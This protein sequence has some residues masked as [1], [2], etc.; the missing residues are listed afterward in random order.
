[1][2]TRYLRKYQQVCLSAI[3]GLAILLTGCGGGGGGGSSTP[4]PTP[5]P[6]TPTPTTPVP[7]ITMSFATPTTNVGTAD[8]LT[9]SATNATSCTAS[10]AWSGVQLVSGTLSVTPTVA[11][12]TTYTLNCMG[13]GG[14]AVPVAVNLTANPISL[15]F[16]ATVSNGVPTNQN[17]SFG[18]YVVK[19]NVWNPAG[20]ATYSETDSG[21]ISLT[22]VASLN[23]AWNVVS[24]SS[25]GI[26][27]FGSIVYGLH[28]GN[29]TSTTTKLPVLV[30]AVPSTALVTGHVITNCLTTCGYD[31]TFDIFVMSS[32]APSNT[33][34][35]VEILIH[36]SDS[37]T[38]NSNSPNGTVT[39]NGVTYQVIYNGFS[40]ANWNN[41]Q[42]LAPAGTSVT[43]LNLNLNSLM[44]DLVARGYINSTDYLVSVEFGTEVG[45][46]SGTTN[47]TNFSVTGF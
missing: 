9:W 13:A 39:W 37:L 15:A 35:G 2:Q 3:L 32:K 14:N 10:G 31:T 19:T 38:T 11:G 17:F 6:V 21:S 30:S 27:S 41:V 24:S 23:M 4:S 34:G 25:P 44:S 7:V 16:D 33:A 12:Q 28:P 46:G 43:D 47:I 20:A 40:V 26:V 29:S 8:V 5:T 45:F 22:E 1:M 42:Y 36:T 18:E